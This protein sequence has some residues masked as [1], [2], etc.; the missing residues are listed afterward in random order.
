MKGLL[1]RHGL[2]VEVARQGEEALKILRQ[3]DFDLVL[4]D[5]NMPLMDGYEATRQIRRNGRQTSLPVI[6]LTANV[7]PEE[8]ERCRRAG[9]NDYLSKPLRRQELEAVLERWLPQG[10]PQAD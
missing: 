2:T 4:M 3:E 9:M 8:R 5:C 10:C 7:M 6:A 1:S